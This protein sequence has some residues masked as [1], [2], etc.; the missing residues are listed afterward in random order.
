M[1][2]P[3]VQDLQ[4]PLRRDLQVARLEVAVNHS[5]GVRC[6]EAVGELDA[7]ADDLPLAERPPGQP[8]A[9]RLAFH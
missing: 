4:V 9:Q 5:L 7:E 2:E 8:L 6:G 3:E 1:R